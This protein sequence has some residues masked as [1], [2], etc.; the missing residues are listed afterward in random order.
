M[1]KKAAALP[2]LADTLLPAQKGDVLA[3]D[4]LWSQ[5]GNNARGECWLWIALCRRTRQVLAYMLGD[6]SEESARWRRECLPPGCACRASR[7]DQWLACR[8]AFP[9]RTHRLCTKKEGE[10]AHAERSF[11][12]ARQRVARLVRKTLSFSKRFEPHELWLRV[13]LTKENLS[14]RQQHSL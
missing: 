5:V 3:C 14:L 12:T 10:T 6:R 11:C 7:S 9:R 2:A 1:G 4:E 8:A 13:F